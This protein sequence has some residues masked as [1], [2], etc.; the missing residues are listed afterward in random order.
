MKKV[1]K[2]KKVKLK[3]VDTFVPGFDLTGVGDIMVEFDPKDFVVVWGDIP[4]TEE[5]L[6]KFDEIKLPKK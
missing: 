2:M 3:P 4:T 1:K 5:Y 6:K